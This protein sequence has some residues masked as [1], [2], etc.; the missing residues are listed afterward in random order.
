MPRIIKLCEKNKFM[1]YERFQVDFTS[2]HML[3]KQA[4]YISMMND[5]ILFLHKHFI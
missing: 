3:Q 5:V 2:N 4:Q 1:S